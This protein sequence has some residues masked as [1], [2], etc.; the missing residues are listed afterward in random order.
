MS[1]RPNVIDIWA[2]TYRMQ[3]AEDEKFI[4]TDVRGIIEDCVEKTLRCVR[5]CVRTE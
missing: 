3:P 1:G 5:V 2:P 4:P